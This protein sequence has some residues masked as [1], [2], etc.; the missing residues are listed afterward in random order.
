MQV[1][2][3][4]APVFSSNSGVGNVVERLEVGSEV[5]TG[6]TVLNEEGLWVEVRVNQRPFGFVRAEDLGLRFN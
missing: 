4:S 1:L 5:E 6:L 3:E 2:S